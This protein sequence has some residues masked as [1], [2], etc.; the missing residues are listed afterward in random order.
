M[1]RRLGL[2]LESASE[3]G[4]SSRREEVDYHQRGGI[5]NGGA[6]GNGKGSPSAQQCSRKKGFEA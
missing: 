5:L 2:G 4:V 3:R 1:H 6:S